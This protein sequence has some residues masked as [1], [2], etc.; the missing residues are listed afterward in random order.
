MLNISKGEPWL[1]WP[2]SICDSLPEHPANKILTG[3]KYFRLKLRLI[4]TDDSTLQKTLFTIV[5]RYTGLDLYESK[6]QLTVTCEDGADYIDLPLLIFPNKEAEIVLEH[7]P[8]QFFK[9]FI[10][11]K[12]VHSVDL[13]NREFGLSDNPHILIGSGNFPK[14]DFNLNF[15][16]FNLVEFEL[17]NENG[18]MSHH[19]FEKFIFDKSVD[20]TG[21]CNF[22]H[23]I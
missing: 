13:S 11:N 22:I 18:V 12:E 6:M 3:D 23:K 9:L 21:N 19:L 5:P 4:L 20:L 8:K 16:A 1:F 15:T 10:D 2:N 7:T 17:R 14:N